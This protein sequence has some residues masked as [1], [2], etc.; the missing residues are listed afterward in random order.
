MGPASRFR[1][2]ETKKVVIVARRL[3]AVGHARCMLVRFAARR[4]HSVM[5]GVGDANGE[6]EEE[7]EG[8]AGRRNIFWARSGNQGRSK[9]RT[10]VEEDGR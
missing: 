4:S 7:E 1:K 2:L 10:K 8:R 5:R 9:P 3:G 6:E